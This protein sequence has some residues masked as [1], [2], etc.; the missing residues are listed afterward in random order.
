MSHV[1]RLTLLRGSADSI[2]SDNRR[3]IAPIRQRRAD[4]SDRE[5]FHPRDASRYASAFPIDTQP[6]LVYRHNL[7]CHRRH[8]GMR[9]SGDVG[10]P[11]EHEC[12][13]RGSLPGSEAH[14]DVLRCQ[15][16][17]R[18]LRERGTEEWLCPRP[19]DGRGFSRFEPSCLSRSP[20]D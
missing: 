20:S 16:A 3:R 7:Y 9:A 4:L 19:T 15:E 14:T 10:H 12:E 13:L 11:R 6:L 17:R 5:A 2:R 18:G 8:P 1:R